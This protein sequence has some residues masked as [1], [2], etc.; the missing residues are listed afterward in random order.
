MEGQDCGFYLLLVTFVCDHISYSNP[1]YCIQIIATPE[2]AASIEI[3][4]IAA[5]VSTISHRRPSHYKS[6][7]LQP[8]VVEFLDGAMIKSLI[9]KSLCCAIRVRRNFL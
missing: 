3:R 9:S 7:G 5:V 1:M 2:V 8:L 6:N 4:D